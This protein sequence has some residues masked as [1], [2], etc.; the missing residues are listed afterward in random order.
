MVLSAGF[1][2]ASLH[3]E[4]K[5]FVIEGEMLV[6]VLSLHMEHQPHHLLL[7]LPKSKAS[8]SARYTKPDQT[9]SVS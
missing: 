8:S 9:V 5:W 3:V 4:M 2:M 1:P 6:G 7:W